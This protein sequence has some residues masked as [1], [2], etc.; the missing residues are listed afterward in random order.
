MTSFASAQFAFAPAL[1]S[2]L[3]HSVWQIA[4]LALA[5]AL[6]LRAMA[7]ASAASRH[8]VA[9][10]FLVAMLVVPAVQFL[11]FWQEPASPLNAGVLAAMTGPE[12]NAANVFVQ[13]SSPLAPVVVL[14]WMAGIALML[15]RHVLS[16]RMLTA[17]DRAPHQPLPPH[18][19]QRVDAMR[20]SLGIARNVAV[21]LSSE[22][23]SPFAAR[24]LRPVIWLPLSLLTRTPAAQLEA[25]L[26]HELAH[27]ARK[28]WLWNGVQCVLESLLF[29]HPA[30]WWLSKRIRQERE[31]A[32]DD[33]AVTAC[34]DAIA[35]AEALAALECDRHSSVFSNPGLVLAANGGSLM[36]RV[37]RLL[38]GPPSRGRWGALAILGA[39]TVSGV[40]L[41][42]QVGIAG[43]RFPELQ[44]SGSTA[45]P[46]GPGDF[47]EIKAQ[48]LDKKRYY[49]ISLDARGRAT[50]SYEENGE[51]RPVDAN[52][53][54]WVDHVTKIAAAPPVH[55]QV[56]PHP[57]VEAMPEHQ[58]LI[59]AIA[60][61]P[62]VV[63]AVGTPAAPTKKPV[64]GNIRLSGAEGEADIHIEMRGPN[65]QAIVAVEGEMQNRIWKLQEV[66]V[67]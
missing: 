56:P 39:L 45:G 8:N 29:F 61:H 9:T 63:A 28:D 42:T 49:R 40:V 48:G 32:C 6:A 57:T 67:Q 14:L 20:A 47:R 36:Q 46:L 65:G 51:P 52:A 4:L 5:A 33:L 16:L 59:A 55:P 3:V 2:A 54:R 66:A 41:I 10:G 22:V 17:M 7:G 27:I 60:G 53:R 62:S 11:R 34:G 21:R 15:I 64:N 35:L 12:L 13:Q 43:G 44:V 25:L 38:S 18:W 31:H 23:L 37:T 50:E 30:M 1:A 26:A 19:Q 24:L 58:A